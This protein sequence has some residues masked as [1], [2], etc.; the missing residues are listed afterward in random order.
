MSWALRL[1]MLLLSGAC[2]GLQADTLMLCYGYGCKLSVP[3]TLSRADWTQIRAQ[4]P[5]P[6]SALQEREAIA[7]S[8]GLFERIAGRVSPIYQDLAGNPLNA[9][10]RPGQL[11]CIDESLNTTSLLILLDQQGLLRW[12]RVEG[13]VFRA[14]WLLDQHWAAEIEQLDTG[15]RYVVDSWPRGNGQPALVQTLEDWRGKVRAGQ[16][17]IE[18]IS[19]DY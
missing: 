15:Q 4:F 8:V 3:V 5:T 9:L 16:P 19:S 1:F 2:T 10:R 17:Q 12:H 13:R 7:Q 18:S 11:Y 6:R 14:P